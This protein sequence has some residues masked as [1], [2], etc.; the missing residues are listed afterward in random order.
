MGQG[1]E[2]LTALRTGLSREHRPLGLLGALP[3]QA[4][5]VA[6]HPWCHPLRK[7][8]KVFFQANLLE[9]CLQPYLCAFVLF[10]DHFVN[11]FIAR[12]RHK[13]LL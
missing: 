10:P 1:R 5:P 6:R 7:E 8:A 2:S 3:H 11:H 13:H 4:C 12:H 9:L